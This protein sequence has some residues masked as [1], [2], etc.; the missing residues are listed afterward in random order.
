MADLDPL[1]KAI[2]Q[3]YPNPERKGCPGPEV[4]ERLARE[5]AVEVVDP[6]D[7]DPENTEHILH[8]SPCYAELQARRALYK[9]GPP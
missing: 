1:R 6:A 7:I 5:T 9:S 3:A 8:C 2:L 4:I